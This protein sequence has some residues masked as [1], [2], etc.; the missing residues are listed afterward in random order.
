MS[1]SKERSKS[2]PKKKDDEPQFVCVASWAVGRLANPF[3]VAIQLND[4]QPFVFEAR[5]ASALA[6]AIQTECRRVRQP[7]AKRRKR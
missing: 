5:E 6:A 7:A 1:E 2:D 4:D 3:R